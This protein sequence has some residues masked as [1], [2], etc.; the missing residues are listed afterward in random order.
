MKKLEFFEPAMCCDTG[1]C[2][3]SID[4]ELLR[5]STVIE[6]VL[7][8]GNDVSRHNLKSDP[9][10]F[11]ANETVAGILKE[12]GIDS[13]PITLVDGKVVATGSYP[14]NERISEL[15]DIEL[16]PTPEPATEDSSCCCPP[17]AASDEGTCCCC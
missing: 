2:G 6:G 1:L 14:S 12:L 17:P 5:V 3:P 9:D 8:S 16:N 10:A 15:L 11:V 4:P 7:K 13:L